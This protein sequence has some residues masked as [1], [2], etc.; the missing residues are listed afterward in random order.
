MRRTPDNTHATEIISWQYLPDDVKKI[1]FRF[2][3]LIDLLY[4]F[5]LVNREFY[6]LLR[7]EFIVTLLPFRLLPH[8]N[9][10]DYVNYMLHQHTLTF[11]REVITASFPVNPV[12]AV[13]LKKF[14]MKQQNSF[15]GIKGK[16]SL[17]DLFSLDEVVYAI[18]SRDPSFMNFMLHD[19][20][21][22]I[23]QEFLH[24][25]KIIH[26]TTDFWGEYSQ[27][28]L[29]YRQIL[30]V[31]IH[32]HLPVCSDRESFYTNRAGFYTNIA[33]F[34]YFS[35]D[36]DFFAANKLV[37]VATFNKFF[38]AGGF[39]GLSF[40]ELFCSYRFLAMF[41][42]LKES[43]LEFFNMIKE[44][45]VGVDMMSF[46]VLNKN[47]LPEDFFAYQELGTRNSLLHIAA[48]SRNLGLLQAVLKCNIDPNLKNANGYIARELPKLEH[49]IRVELWKGHEV[50]PV[51]GFVD[52]TTNLKKENEMLK[53]DMANM[54]ETM[55]LLIQVVGNK[56]STTDQ[57]ETL[58]KCLQQLSLL[59]SIKREPASKD[60]DNRIME[61]FNNNR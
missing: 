55:S 27:M 38:F 14:G 19:W 52:E 5:R 4:S 50:L 48:L 32:Q 16:I 45:S 2:S 8:Q 31:F 17:V 42:K 9:K 10:R 13:K 59:Q 37:S 33:A 15:L 40:Q 3:S 47:Y 22:V 12:I 46:V 61:L 58:N 49:E 39:A 35:G 25:K 20:N 23:V 36:A 41:N 24:E 18:K 7:D 57:K 21:L 60:N 56:V 51:A 28:S 1:I 29:F 26:L 43:R 11:L 30:S 54:A 34:F 44:N 6:N 53:A